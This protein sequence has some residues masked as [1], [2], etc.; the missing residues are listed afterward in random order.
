V[1]EDSQESAGQIQVAEPLV[2]GYS[3][4]ESRAPA[5][6]IPV[7]QGSSTSSTGEDPADA[8]PTA[9]LEATAATEGVVPSGMPT[10][11]PTAAPET[12]APEVTV[13]EAIA[14]ENTTLEAT[15]AAEPETTTPETTVPDAALQKVRCPWTFQA[16]SQA[17]SLGH[18]QGYAGAGL[19]HQHGKSPR[20]QHYWVLKAE[21]NLSHQHQ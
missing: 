15:E 14:P 10:S 12:A 9:A 6:A 4:S 19:W 16:R 20:L 17:R 11:H 8:L 18:L 7:V 5:G 3:S 13:S 21:T 2:Q 1:I